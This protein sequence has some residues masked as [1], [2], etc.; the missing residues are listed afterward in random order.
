MSF[1]NLLFSTKT[2]PKILI[3]CCLIFVILSWILLFRDIRALKVF[4]LFYPDISIFLQ[5]TREFLL[6]KGLN[7]IPTLLFAITSIVAFYFYFKSL[8][9]KI[10]GK[11]T[12]IYAVLFQFIIFFSYPIL[13]TDIFSYIVTSRV[14]VIHDSNIWKVSPDH[15]P[16]DPFL[17]LSDWKTIPGIYGY[18]DQVFYN[19]TSYI[20]QNNLFLNLLLNKLLVLVFAILTLLVIHKILTQFYDDSALYGIRLIFWNPL[21]LLEI[22]GAGHNDILMIFFM[23]L[24]YYFYLEKRFFLFGTFIALS[25]QT[26]IIPIFLLMFIVGKLIMDKKIKELII[27]SIPFLIINSAGFYLMQ[28]S[29][30]QY[31]QRL[32]YNTGINWQSLQALIARFGIEAHGLFTILFVICIVSIF[33]IQ[34]IK[35]IDPMTSY[36]TL[37]L[38]YLLVIASAYWNWYVLWILVFLPFIKNKRLVT[39]GIVFSFT[40]LFA[41]PTYWTSLRFHHQHIIWA[42][43]LYASIFIVPVIAFYFRKPALNILLKQKSSSN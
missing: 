28:L 18:A 21:F 1:S 38:I 10:S 2:Y 32:Q 30:F 37:I 24:A 19:A 40:S 35:K 9:V 6:H 7:T 39:L 17:Q 26:K 43:I 15:F 36:V 23:L 11:T 33:V 8:A 13:S 31:F 16:K 4:G 12:I 22:I 25:V 41:Y 27:L 42:V 34:L 20:S 14:A 5:S 29:P 3:F